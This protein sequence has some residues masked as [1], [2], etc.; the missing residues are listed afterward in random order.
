MNLSP[1]GEKFIKHFESCELIAYPDPGTNGEPFTIGWGHTGS[2]VCEGMVWS[3]E[4][5]DKM[6]ICDIAPREDSVNSLLIVEVTQW[7]FDALVSFVYNLG[8]GAFSGST[9]L[10]KIN[11]RDYAGAAN[12]FPRW[13]RAAGRIMR[14][15]TRRRYAER[16]LFEGESLEDALR[17]GRE[18]A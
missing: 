2:D 14:G 5:A 15:L 3:Q 13:N 17:I 10:R 16:A 7:Q 4:Y 18:A 1:T 6:F 8:A 9:L 12:E 11:D